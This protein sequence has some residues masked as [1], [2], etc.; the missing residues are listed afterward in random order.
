MLYHLRKRRPERWANYTYDV[1]NSAGLVIT[2]Y[3]SKWRAE[4]LIS[5]MNDKRFYEFS[6]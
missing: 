4:G 3:D 2:S 5:Y 1:L 6:K